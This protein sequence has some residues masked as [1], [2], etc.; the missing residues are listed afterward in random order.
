METPFLGYSR[1]CPLTI[2]AN[3]HRAPPARDDKACT[4]LNASG[5]ANCVALLWQSPW[6][7][8]L[9]FQASLQPILWQ[10]RRCRPSQN[11][12]NLPNPKAKRDLGYHPSLEET[13]S[14]T[15]TG[16]EKVYQHGHRMDI[17]ESI[18]PS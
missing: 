7:I 10:T 18:I 6:K 4:K 17:N 2:E 15:S 8:F 11:G 3:Y 14:K 13:V 12:S 1:F 5:K 16:M 9:G